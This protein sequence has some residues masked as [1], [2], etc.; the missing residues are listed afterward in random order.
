MEPLGAFHF[1]TGRFAPRHASEAASKACSE[2]AANYQPTLDQ[3]KR[4][5]N[6]CAG[7]YRVRTKFDPL[8]FLEEGR[9]A[10]D[11]LLGE[12]CQTAYAEIRFQNLPNCASDGAKNGAS[13][14]FLAFLTE[15]A[16]VLPFE[17]LPASGSG[18]SFV[19]NSQCKVLDNSSSAILEAPSFRCPTVNIGARQKG[20][21]RAPSV[22]D[23]AEDREAIQ[24]AID[25]ALSPEFTAIADAGVSPY[26]RDGKAGQKISS[27]LREFDLTGIIQ[28]R[29]HDLG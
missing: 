18:A 12:Q 13:E 20:R 19:G 5:E 6:S 21:V 24:G 8:V 10:E 7:L 15:D 27:I 22:I 28:K 4:L 17:N 23:C 26:F 1:V 9:L 25:R 29:F 16:K 3:I 11:R 2:A 14:P